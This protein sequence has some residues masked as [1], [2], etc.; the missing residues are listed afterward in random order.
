MLKIG[1]IVEN[2][3]LTLYQFTSFDNKP[4]IEGE[5]LNFFSKQK[6][7]FEYITESGL[8]DENAVLSLCIAS[9]TSKKFDEL[10]RTRKNKNKHSFK[11]IK[12]DDVSI[13]GIYGPH[14]REKP[15]IAVTFFILLGAAGINILGI[16]TSISSVCCIIPSRKHKLAKQA[17]MKEFE[18]P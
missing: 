8:S 16:S 3:N 18:L 4:G 14:F 13:I 1:G 11:V 6:I 7:N 5:I 12:T 9:D 2:K 17:I 10:L 15:Q